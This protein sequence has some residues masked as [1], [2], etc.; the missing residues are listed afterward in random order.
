M[1]ILRN[2]WHVCTR[3][4][5]TRL[6][7]RDAEDFVYGMNG[8]AICSHGMKLAVLAFCLMGN[9]VHFVLNG[10]ERAVKDFIASY[11]KRTGIWI[12]NRYGETAPLRRIDVL[13]KPVLNREQLATVVSYVHRNPLAAGLC[14]PISY[15]WSSASVFF[16]QRR[17]KSGWRRLGEIPPRQ[18]RVILKTRHE[19]LPPDWFVN[20][21][22]MI[23][24]QCYLRIGYVERLYG[25]SA[26]NYMYSL[27]TN[28]DAE[29]EILMMEG[30]RAFPDETMRRKIPVLCKEHFGKD[31]FDS[32]EM[33]D[34][35]ALAVIMHRQYSCPAKQVSRLTGMDPVVVSRLFGKED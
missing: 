35:Y 6:I 19:G 27:N 34:K 23:L 32:L 31:S 2:C 1:E 3:G 15:E 25:R 7:F 10:E 4:L 26:S 21:E 18:A 11:I 29:T 16:S 20:D 33:N 24:P 28:K 14:T 13:A 17:I 9:H 30:M 12:G 22:G 8:V 5:K